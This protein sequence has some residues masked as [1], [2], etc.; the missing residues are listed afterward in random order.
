M[1]AFYDKIA[2]ML[3][4]VLVL[5][6]CSQPTPKNQEQKQ[7]QI[8]DGADI[9]SP[10]PSN[11]WVQIDENIR[12]P[13]GIH[14]S[15]AFDWAPDDRPIYFHTIEDVE[16]NRAQWE[17]F[18]A[19]DNYLNPNYN[20]I[21]WHFRIQ[22]HAP[23]DRHF[24]NMP[25]GWRGKRGAFVGFGEPF[26][27]EYLHMFECGDGQSIVKTYQVK[28]YI[29]RCNN[30]LNIRTFIIPNFDAPTPP[31]ASHNDP[32][33]GA[34]ENL[35]DRWLHWFLDMR[36]KRKLA[37][38]NIP[39]NHSTIKRLNVFAYDANSTNG[40]KTER[41]LEPG[42]IRNDVNYQWI[43]N[44]FRAPAHHCTNDGLETLNCLP[45]NYRE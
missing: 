25:K 43:L 29:I 3:L 24:A 9:L 44:A 32:G 7:A 12:I 39:T 34:P 22:G 18:F 13:V 37:Y 6:A 41:L 21:A 27:N 42:A 4:A 16:R 38:E 30:V 10:P 8:S 20:R 19:P 5:T 15:D 31:F 33:R 28:D 23:Y 26:S 35:P 11:R 40:F 45:N 14:A 17:P 1:R 36:E 2:L